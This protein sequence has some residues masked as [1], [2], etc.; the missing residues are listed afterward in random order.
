MPHHGGVGEI[1]IARCIGKHDVPDGVEDIAVCA[2]NPSPSRRSSANPSQVVSVWQCFPA[3]RS[4]SWD[5]QVSVWTKL[6]QPRASTGVIAITT[7]RPRG[8]TMALIDHRRATRH[9]PRQKANI[10]VEKQVFGLARYALFFWWREPRGERERE[11]EM[12][13]PEWLEPNPLKVWLR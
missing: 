5:K 12:V 4:A 2:A 8:V 10:I 9:A 13:L 7:G 11:R 1:V 6:G 3:V